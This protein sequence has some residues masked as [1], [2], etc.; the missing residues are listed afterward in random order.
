MQFDINGCVKLM[1]EANIPVDQQGKLVSVA[2]ARSLGYSLTIPTSAVEAPLSHYALNEK[3]LVDEAIS[4]VNESLSIDVEK[5]SALVQAF[6]LFRYRLVYDSGNIAVRNFMDGLVKCGS[7]E[8][9]GYVSEFLIN[10]ESDWILDRIVGF[11]RDGLT[12][13]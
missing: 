6:W 13:G 10:L 9:P 3:T 7:K 11:I 4:T 1:T 12:G 8:F 2:L 5:T